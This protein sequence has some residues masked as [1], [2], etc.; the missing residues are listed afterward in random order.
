MKT[1]QD[2]TPVDWFGTTKQRRFA[3]TAPDTLFP[4]LLPEVKPP[5][6]MP[7][8]PPVL[9]GQGDLFASDAAEAT[10]PPAGHMLADLGNVS[11]AWDLDVRLCQIRWGQV[12]CGEP[13]TVVL[14]VCCPLEHPVHFICA[15][16]TCCCEVQRLDECPECGADSPGFRVTQI[17]KH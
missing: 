3:D 5:R 2:M 7:P 14:Q 9:D 1:W 17:P 8:A 12:D 11:V 16:A 13:A 10:I 15:C 4:D 6:D